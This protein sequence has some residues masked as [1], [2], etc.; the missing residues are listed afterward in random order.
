MGDTHRLGTKQGI[1]HRRF[2]KFVAGTAAL[3]GIALGI[4]G[5]QEIKKQQRDQSSIDTATLSAFLDPRDPEKKLKPMGAGTAVIGHSSEGN[6]FG[7]AKVGTAGAGVVLGRN[8][9][10]D[11]VLP[12]PLDPSRLDPFKKRVGGAAGQ[13]AVGAVAGVVAGQHG[14]AAGIKQVAGAV[15]GAAWREAPRDPIQEE[16]EKRGRG[17]KAGA[18]IAIGAEGKQASNKELIG[19]L[20]G[21]GQQRVK[22]IF[23]FGG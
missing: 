7:G 2:K 6:I 18:T 8:A 15:A 4:K 23:R 12:Q 19:Q 13:A 10:A 14:A 17:A 20:A 11:H 22:G 3:G 16:L 1:G 5:D 9:P 21:K